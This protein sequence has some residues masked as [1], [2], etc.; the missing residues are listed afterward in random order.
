MVLL[1][2]CL[3]IHIL[4]SRFQA[5]NPHIGDFYY[6]FLYCSSKTRCSRDKSSLIWAHLIWYMH[7]CLMEK[8]ASIGSLSS[9]FITKITD[10][11]FDTFHTRFEYTESGIWLVESLVHL[12]ESLIYLFESTMHIS[13]HGYELLLKGLHSRKHLLF[14][15]SIW[16]RHMMN[17][18]KYMMSISFLWEKSKKSDCL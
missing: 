3:S 15:W 1:V 7:E 10:T 2:Y 6:R 14:E 12:L 16:S 4:Y 11:L 13:S 5:K 9:Y 17:T 18:K 8:H